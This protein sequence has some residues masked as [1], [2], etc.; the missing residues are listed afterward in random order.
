MAYNI[1]YEITTTVA[2]W[3]ENIYSFPSDDY[4]I[5]NNGG[6]TTS[7]Y[8]LPYCQESIQGGI[9]HWINKNVTVIFE[10]I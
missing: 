6:L 10:N 7:D 2:T 5:Y 8:M 3:R 4:C 9:L 1:N